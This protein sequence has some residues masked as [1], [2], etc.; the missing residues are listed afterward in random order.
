M[1]KQYLHKRVKRIRKCWKHYLAGQQGDDLHKMRVEIKK[2]IALLHFLK[3][4]YPEYKL[5]LNTRFI[6]HAFSIS[7]DIRDADNIRGLSKRFHIAVPTIRDTDD[8]KKLKKGYLGLR[9][10]LNRTTSST[11]KYWKQLRV[12][13]LEMYINNEVLS[14]RRQIKDGLEKEQLHEFRKKLKDVYYLNKILQKSKIGLP[15]LT[16]K[17]I[18]TLQDS[19]G[20]WH[21]LVKFKTETV[22][23]SRQSIRSKRLVN[24]AEKKLL[25]RIGKLSAKLIHQNG[26]N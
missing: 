13:H 7:G 8:I 24:A 16:V 10:E 20:K 11:K 17:H 1:F 26:I 23:K 3:H 5:K 9:E 18:N 2:L 14:M 12:K 21:D 15:L 19:I 25:I 22:I 6:R 4:E